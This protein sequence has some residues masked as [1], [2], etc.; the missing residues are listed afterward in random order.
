MEMMNATDVCP[1][2]NNFKNK[3]RKESPKTLVANCSILEGKKTTT[4]LLFHSESPSAWHTALCTKY[5]T[6]RKSSTGKGRQITIN[7]DNDENYPFLTIMS[8]IM[9]PSWFRGQKAA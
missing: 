4:N 2:K 6:H 1:F 3:V 7:E 5:P 8:T 9:T